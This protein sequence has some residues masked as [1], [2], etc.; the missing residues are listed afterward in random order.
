MPA[1]LSCRLKRAYD[2][3]GGKE[4][5]LFGQPI[6]GRNQT[7]HGFTPDAVLSLS[8]GDYR[9][10][11]AAWSPLVSSDRKFGDS[12]HGVSSRDVDGVDPCD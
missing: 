10:P 3:S 8:K 11:P 2:F 1:S 7:Q 4:R 6:V 5:V 12:G 9:C